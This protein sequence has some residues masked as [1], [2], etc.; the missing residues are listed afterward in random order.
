MT[1][2]EMMADLAAAD[3]AGDT[4]LAQAIAARIKAARGPRLGASHGATPA[5]DPQT[6]KSESGV[7]GALQGASMGFGDEASAA[8][9]SVLPSFL[10]NSVSREA[11]GDAKTLGERYRNA[12]DYYR[13]RN[14]TAEESNPGT[15]LAGQVAGAAAPALVGGASVSAAR[16]LPLAAG[17]GAAQGAGYSEHEGLDRLGDTALGA[18]LGLTGY[19]AGRVVGKVGAAALRKGRDLVQSGTARA[20][21]QA[22]GEVAEEVASKAGQVGGEVQKG[23]RQVENLMRLEASMTPQQRALY[24]QLQSAGVVPDLQQA[25]A[26]STL[27]ALPSQAATIA[28]RKAELAALQGAAPQ[29]AASRTADL[30][31]PQVKADAKSFLKQY[32]EPLAWGIGT[33]QAADLLGADAKTQAAAG[34]IAGAIGG[35]TRA[36]KALY[37]RLTR[38]AHQAAL[39]RALEKLGTTT[40]RGQAFLRALQRAGVAVGAPAVVDDE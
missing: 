28:A 29:A 20:G 15:Y 4:Q 16:A 6:T 5:Y 22:A 2:A 30:L 1:E 35:R 37:T 3:A 18:A 17:Q 14:A 21:A 36:G 27:E 8:V 39:G 38:P 31:K 7:R 13:N 10:R 24:G 32:A 33:Q 26:Q 25:V 19:G 40:P 34:V 9:E 23:S 11:V 12:R